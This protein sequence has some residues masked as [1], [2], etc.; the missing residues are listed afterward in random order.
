V[1]EQVVKQRRSVV[2]Q[3]VKLRRSVVEQIAQRP[4]RDPDLDSL[5]DAPA[6][7]PRDGAEGGT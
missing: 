3:V 5:A 2:E 1:V 7:P 6:R 4:C